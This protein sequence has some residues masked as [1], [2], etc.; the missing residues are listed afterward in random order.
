MKSEPA[1][2]V[3]DK[4]LARLREIGGGRLVGD[5]IATFLRNAPVRIA[6]AQQGLASS[7][8]E[9]V[10][11]AGHS[12]KSSC[13]NVGATAMRDIAAE[14]EQA[15]SAHLTIAALPDLVGRL[16]AAF[17]AVRPE[18]EALR[19]SASARPCVAVVEDNSDNR[20]LVRAML[21]DSYEIEEYEN[22][23]E[24]LQSFR[25]R[26]PALILLDISLPGM[27]GGQ[28]LSAIRSDP[29]LH[30]LPV[31]ALTAHA[32]A[33]DREK[34]L[35]AGFDDYVAKPIVDERVLLGAIERLMRR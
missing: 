24:A 14:L 20:L 29:A 13:G 11:R 22:G 1:R 30:A 15:A 21:E 25:L 7:D 4:A 19:E 33:G 10:M 5:L 12:L 18:L 28:V 2:L 26:R 27:D 16:A 17:E 35:S 31:V 23:G 6:D 3:D 9:V 34:Y 32:M 8:L